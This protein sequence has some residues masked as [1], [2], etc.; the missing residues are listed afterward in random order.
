MAE[1]VETEEVETEELD[2]TAEVETEQAGQSGEDGKTEDE[3]YL[4]LD[5]GRVTYK[6]KDDAVAG[7]KH[8]NEQLGAY[9]KLG[10]PAEIE[11]QL[12]E[13]KAKQDLLETLRTGT[14]TEKVEAEE[15]YLD[16]L[17]AEK[18]Q[19]WEASAKP[20]R[21]LLK[22]DLGKIGKLEQAI[23]DLKKDRETEKQERQSEGLQRFRQR[24]LKDLDT[25]LEQSGK[26]LT[27]N[28]KRRLE[29]LA[30]SLAGD[31]DDP[32]GQE[33]L[34]AL[35]AEDSKAFALKAAQVYLGEEA[36]KP[37]PNGSKPGAGDDRPRD[38]KTGQF[39]SEDETERRKRAAADKASRL[40]K[41]PPDDSSAASDQGGNTKPLPIGKRAGTFADKLGEL[42][43][44]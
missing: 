5:E 8:Y 31:A 12:T 23:A 15:R 44:R 24:S 35:N 34:Q 43:G 21:E 28:Q 38:P 14:K 33:L 1:D 41:A 17:P 29:K 20:I 11:R 4:A 7:F 32:D 26:T 10:K 42:L 22:D 13:A 37:A 36:I 40:A 18:R 3:P 2:E 16:T 19:A 25:L 6:T 39:L 30:I 9:R 27:D